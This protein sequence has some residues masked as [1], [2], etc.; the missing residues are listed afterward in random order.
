MQG[1]KLDPVAFLRAHFRRT[2]FELERMEGKRKPPCT[3]NA[4]PLWFV[5]SHRRQWLEAS[6]LELRSVGQ[7]VYQIHPYPYTALYI[8]SNEL[9]LLEPL[10]PFLVTRT[11]EAL[12]E[13]ARWII[14]YK[15]R[16]QAWVWNL[17]EVMHMNDA[18]LEALLDQYSP[19]PDDIEAIEYHRKL[20]RGVLKRTP[21]VLREVTEQARIETKREATIEIITEMMEATLERVMTDPERHAVKQTLDLEGQAHLIRRPELRS[22]ELLEG[23]FAQLLTSQP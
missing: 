22:K 20:V 5:T 8:A 3:L 10:L 9:P 21:E 18:Q 13:F 23:W 6:P 2:A 1:D 19:D 12:V 14:Q 17:F 11:G 16:P 7:G 15:I 4:L